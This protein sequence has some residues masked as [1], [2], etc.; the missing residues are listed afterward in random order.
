VHFLKSVRT[1]GLELAI[2]DHNHTFAIDL[3]EDPLH[4]TQFDSLEAAHD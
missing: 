1:N 3:G 2:T 4:A